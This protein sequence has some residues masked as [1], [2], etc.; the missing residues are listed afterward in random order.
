M[1]QANGG[2]AAALAKM[3]TGIDGLDRITGGG[4]PRGR[5]TLVSGGPGCGKTVLALQ[6]LAD[7]AR[8]WQ[9]P[10]I[11][12][13]FEEHARDILSNAAS[14]GW[15][16]PALQRRQLCFIDARLSPGTVQAGAFDLTALLAAV[17]AQA[18]AMGAKRIVFDG[19]D[20]LLSVLDDPARERQE[21]Y[22]LHDWLAH[23]GL[24]AVLTSKTE[25][26][27]ALQRRHGFLEFLVDCAIALNHEVVD[28]VSL[29]KLRVLK[30]RGSSFAGN[31]MPF[32]I[33]RAG[34]SVGD[35]GPV[36][37]G[38]QRA[39]TARV[40]TGVER[41]DAM[42]GGGYFRGSSVLLSGSPGT[43]KST[44]AGCFIAAAGARGERGLY[45]SFD[46]TAGEIVRNLGSVG[47]RLERHIKAGRVQVHG[48]DTA[49]HSVEEHLLALRARIRAQRPS[50][51]VIDPV[52]AM[53][54]AGGSLAAISV[55]QRLLR[56]AKAEGITVLCTSLLGRVRREVEGSL[57]PISTIADTW[58]HLS[59]AARGGER[60][61]GLSIIKARGT[62]HSNQ[63][64]ELVLSEKGVT[65]ADVYAAGG[66]V[67]MGTARWQREQA[68]GQEA[69][70]LRAEIEHQRRA[71][72]L[73][74][75]EALVRMQ[76]VQRELKE[77]RSALEVLVRRATARTE[78]RQHALNRFAELDSA[79]SA[80][81]AATARR[82]RAARTGSTQ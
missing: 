21:V 47:I 29:R 79:A 80:T 37:S 54:K 49:A 20:M 42:L 11:F 75:A 41:L 77:R 73:A 76:A 36:G 5:T 55:A 67:L 56:G 8:R 26:D 60:N 46:E 66:D 68:E 2:A 38:A 72:E 15:N 63:V 53:I 71:L 50:C 9:E 28:R 3:P 22:R 19:I 13:A 65:L 81:P 69:E 27:A 17:A 14:F 59:Y 6:T 78:S 10:G 58:I 57:L 82:R 43:A 61:R 16:L 39:P 34:I 23:Q 33:D 40:S 74:E 1:G 18:A 45:V 30:Y 7:G 12:V 24:S 25:A 31:E 32:T 52:S 62:K 4:L 44:L 64:R 48:A 70:R 51:L 35:T